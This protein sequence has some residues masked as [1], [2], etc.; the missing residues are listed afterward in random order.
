MNSNPTNVIQDT[1]N[2]N[3]IRVTT[4]T[5]GIANERVRDLA[6]YALN[7]Q[8]VSTAVVKFLMC[9]DISDE[10]IYGVKVG[11][12]KDNELRI[13]VE[14]RE[15]ALHKKGKK[16]SQNW[17]NF[18]NPNVDSS[19]IDDY[20]YKAWRN[21]LYHGKKKN[22]QCRRIRRN[23]NDKYVAININPEVFLAFVYNVNFCDSFYKISAPAARWKSSKQLDDMSGKERKR[24]RAMQQ[25]FS[26]YGITQCKCIVITFRQ[27]AT[28]KLNNGEIITGFHPNQV[29]DFHSQDN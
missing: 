24:Y 15:K 20:F 25:E 5:L 16:Q 27:D 12:T 2:D 4:Q 22:L 8:E 18:D 1:V 17:M 6:G 13:I 29:D 3:S 28:Y 21:K 10:D 7:P 9:Y 23:D 19:L 26:N 14:V 11:T